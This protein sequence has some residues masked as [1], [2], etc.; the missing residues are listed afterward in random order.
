M[1]TT[2]MTPLRRAGSVKPTE[3]SAHELTG[4]TREATPGYFLNK[5]EHGGYV[6]VAGRDQARLTSEYPRKDRPVPRRLHTV[7]RFVLPDFQA[8]FDHRSRNPRWNCHL[9]RDGLHP[10]RQPVDSWRG[11]PQRRSDHARGHRRRHRACRGHHD[12]P[13]G[14][15]RQLPPRSRRRPRPQRRRRLHPGAR[16]GPE[17][18]RGHGRHRLGRYPHLPAGSDRL[19]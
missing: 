12:D 7:T 1:R 9:L 6:C 4:S 2:P 16:R 13:H 14:R 11:H 5:W 17:L 10:G 19:P 8:R 3:A 15:R 18:R